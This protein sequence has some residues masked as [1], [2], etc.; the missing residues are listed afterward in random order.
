[1]NHKHDIKFMNTLA[2]PALRI[3]AI[4]R[5]QFYR[6]ILKH[7]AVLL[8]GASLALA[9]ADC[10]PAATTGAVLAAIINIV[11]LAAID[12]KIKLAYVEDRPPY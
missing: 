3:R 8:I 11:L 9:I 10:P 2:D 7:S 12:L 6:F 1:M 5:W 4:R